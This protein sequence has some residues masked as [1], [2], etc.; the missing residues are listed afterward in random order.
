MGKTRTVIVSTHILSEVEMLCSRVIIISGGKK[1]ADSP[2]DELK[3]KYS[4][5]AVISLSVAKAKDS[6][7]KN[8]VLALP[9]VA[10]CTL[11]TEGDIVKALINVNGSEEIRPAL[12]RLVCKNGWD[13][14]SLDMQKNS[15]EEVF[16]S[17]TIQGDEK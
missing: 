14:L 16:R 8:A 2:T 7:L 11:S 17:L 10:G 6:E 15:L 12:A 5:N 13:M 3:T 1:V 9:Q 4:Q